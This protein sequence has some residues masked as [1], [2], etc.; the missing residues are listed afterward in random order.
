M[1]H[2][3]N[4]YRDDPAAEDAASTFSAPVNALSAQP[5]LDCGLGALPWL[6]SRLHLERFAKPSVYVGLLCSVAFFQGAIVSYFRSTSHIWKEHYN[7]EADT[8]GE[9]KKMTFSSFVWNIGKIQQH[10]RVKKIL[11]GQLFILNEK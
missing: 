10:L 4:I 2:P 5:P 6:S 1:I 8:T 3:S 11:Q 9:P 7:F